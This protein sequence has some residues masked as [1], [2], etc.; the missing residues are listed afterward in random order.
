MSSGALE[1]REASWDITH[2]TEHRL[3]SENLAF[4]IGE[5]DSE[6][7]PSALCSRNVCF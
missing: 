3:R 6:S 5:E 4:D 1:N 7:L 2:D